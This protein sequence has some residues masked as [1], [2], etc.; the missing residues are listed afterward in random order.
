MSLI[1]PKKIN[2]LMHDWPAGT[3]YVS[4]WLKDAGISGQLLNRYKKSGWLES[5]GSGAIKRIGDEVGYQGALYAL[6]SQLQSSIHVGGKSALELQGRLHY[7]NFNNRFV[8]LFGHWKEHLPLWFSNTDWGVQLEY[9][10]TSFLPAD[11]EVIDFEVKDFS[12]KISSPLR[13]MF[14]CLYL[15]PEKQGLIECYELMEG[16]NNLRPLQVQ[17]ILETCE[18]I[19]VKRLFVFMADR[20]GHAWLKH[21]DLSNINF[22][23]GKRS[24]VS[25]GLLN[26]KYQITL[27]KELAE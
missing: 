15:A 12:I 13:A 4:S 22:G 14:E 10:R 26:T 9:H 11:L 21:V 3:V 16:L 25:G 24:I 17:K 7:L 8:T 23:V 6:Q 2:Q 18:S 20:A 1:N 27:P 19:K 5:V